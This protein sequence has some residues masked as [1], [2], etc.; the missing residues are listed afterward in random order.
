MIEQDDLQMV[1]VI[2]RFGELT[3]SDIAFKTGLAPSYVKGRLIS[4]KA[5][6]FVERETVSATGVWSVSDRMVAL[7]E[8]R[9]GSVDR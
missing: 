1:G 2:A 7:A 4:L 5:R 9:L 8:R 6:G 3:T